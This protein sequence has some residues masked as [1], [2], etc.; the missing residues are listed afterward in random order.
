MKWK[1]SMWTQPYV[2]YFYLSLFKLQFILVWTTRR[3]LKPPRIRIS[4][5]DAASSSQGRLEDA[6]FGG[7]MVEVAVKPAATDKKSG[8]MGFFWIWTWS[9][10]EKEMTGKL[11]ASRNSENSGDSKAGSRKWPHHFHMS[12]AVVPHVEEVDRTTNLRPKSNGWLG[13]HSKLQFI[14][15][16]TFWRIYDLPN[17]NSWSLWNRY[18]KWLKGW[19]RIRQKLGVWPQLTTNSLLEID[20]STVWHSC[21]DCVSVSNQSKPGRTKVEWYLETRYLKDLNRID[22]EPMELEWNIFPGFTTMGIIGEIQRI[23]DWSTVWTWAVQR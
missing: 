4:K 10:H 23:W 9:N 5:P 15:V 6:Y 1:T 2:V 19:L 16:E 12:P 7:L 3:I 20:D 22:G 14:L 17:I 21:W 18:F 8:I 11:V 13:W